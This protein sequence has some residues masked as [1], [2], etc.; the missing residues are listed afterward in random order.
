M[1]IRET[2]SNWIELEE[3]N[4]YH[5]GTVMYISKFLGTFTM[6]LVGESSETRFFRHLSNHVF[7][8]RNLGNTKAMRVIFFF[9]T[10]KIS[11]RCQKCRKKRHKVFSFWNNCIW[12]GIV[13]FYLLRTEYLWSAANVLKSSPKCYM[14]IRETFSDSVSLPVTNEYDESTVM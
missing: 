1:S 2:F 12:N 7:A 4:E 8:V 3:I 13:N 14:A 9:R 6:L 5:K 10:F 11:A